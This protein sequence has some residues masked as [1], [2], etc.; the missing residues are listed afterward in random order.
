VASDTVPI[1]ALARCTG[2]DLDVGN[3]E[4][5][6]EDDG[7]DEDGGKDNGDVVSRWTDRE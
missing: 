4:D 7:E 5:G 3:A 6:G 1:G 2:Y